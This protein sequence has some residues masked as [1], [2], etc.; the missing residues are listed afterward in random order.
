M[1]VTDKKIWQCDFCNGTS[2]TTNFGSKPK[3]W[4]HYCLTEFDDRGNIFGR[5]R[6]FDACETCVLDRYH[7]MSPI[8]RILGKLG[9]WRR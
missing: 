4:R 2:E 3:G 7:S 9:H 1:S 5:P 8:R 6:E